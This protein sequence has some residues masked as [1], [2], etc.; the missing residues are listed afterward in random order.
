MATARPFTYN[1]SLVP[2]DG[3]IQVGDLA[4]GFPTS[5][6]TDSP[7]FWNGPDEELGYVIAQSAPSNTESTP[8]V[9]ETASVNFF[10]SSDLTENSFIQLT[11]SVFNQ[12]FT[13]GA[14][15][16]DWLFAN[17]YWT[18]YSPI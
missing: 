18:S 17:G 16:S 7:Q 10:R 3:T 4:V 2:I 1:P 13:T 12:S 14:D 6:F 8:I 5:G 11:N 15:A 9:G